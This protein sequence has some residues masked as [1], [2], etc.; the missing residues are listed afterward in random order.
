MQI[1]SS[2]KSGEEYINT[3]GAEST[4]LLR[5]SVMPSP[6]LRHDNAGLNELK[7]GTANSRNYKVKINRTTQTRNKARTILE[8]PDRLA[9]GLV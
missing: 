1:R 7:R 6:C 3:S 9:S 2:V 4:L 8:L 5:R